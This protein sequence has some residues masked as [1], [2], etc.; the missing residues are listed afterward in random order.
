MENLSYYIKLIPLDRYDYETDKNF[1]YEMIECWQRSE[2]G[3]FLSKHQ[4]SE[5]EELHDMAGDRI[6]LVIKFA[7]SPRDV[8]FFNL[9]FGK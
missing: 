5:I 1:K 9:K 3:K 2:R 6:I 7:L 8:T 4:V